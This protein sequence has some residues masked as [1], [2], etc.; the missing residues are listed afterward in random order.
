MVV[1]NTKYWSRRKRNKKNKINRESVNY[2]RES[3]SM[4]TKLKKLDARKQNSTR[5]KVSFRLTRVVT[6]TCRRRIRRS[7]LRNRGTNKSSR[8]P[9][10]S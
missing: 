4:T 9:R 7:V 8:E 5:S 3:F 2:K 6:A 10:R 1:A